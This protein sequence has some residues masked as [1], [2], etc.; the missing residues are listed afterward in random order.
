MLTRQGWGAAL[1]RDGL[2]RTD[3]LA[4]H[5]DNLTRPAIEVQV[6]SARA[7]KNL[8]YPLGL[9]SQKI[10]RSDREWFVFVA[11]PEQDD[12]RSAPRSFVVPRDHVA[13]A[14]H[15]SHEDWRT[16]PNAAPGTRNAGVDMS[17]VGLWVWEDYEDRWDLLA[18]PTTEVPV[19]LPAHFEELAFGDRVGLPENHPWSTARPTWG[20][21]AGRA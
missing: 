13:A 17:R 18:H 1:T 16:D 19:L 21:P 15:I 2:E 9:T 11:L 10:A 6:K 7:A 20:E 8:N 12:F 5:T 4:V 3:I 14:A